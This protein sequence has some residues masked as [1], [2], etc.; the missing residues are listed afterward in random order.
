MSF[1]LEGEAATNAHWPVL[2]GRITPQAAFLGLASAVTAMIMI[3]LMDQV[4]MPD[5]TG[6]QVGDAGGDRNGGSTNIILQLLH[7]SGSTTAVALG[8]SNI[9]L[10]PITEEI[11][12]RG[13]L[14][15]TLALWY[16]LP[17]ALAVT[18][19]AF[20]LF[21]LSPDQLPAL[22]LLGFSLGGSLVLAR[23]NLFAPILGHILYNSFVFGSL[24]T[25][26]LQ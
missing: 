8:L 19:L 12:W 18:S 6:I 11:V 21:H 14:I 22:S 1:S 16:G 24:L 15:P 4:V 2:Q 5:P 20:G 7:S 10:G 23:A 26:A 3:A 9:V 25:E 13:L 17:S